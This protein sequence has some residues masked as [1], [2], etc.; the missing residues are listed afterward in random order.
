M[1]YVAGSRAVAGYLA[2]EMVTV[3][4][5]LAPM[6]HL[7]V[8]AVDSEVLVEEDT[9]VAVAVDIAAL[10]IAVVDS[11]YCYRSPDFDSDYCFGYYD[12]DFLHRTPLASPA[13]SLRVSFGYP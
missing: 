2:Y 5:Q 1:V 11:D 4:L 12:S 3:H 8:A 13:Q 7:A 10:D 6:I 9:V